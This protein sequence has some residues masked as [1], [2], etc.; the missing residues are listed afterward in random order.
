MWQGTKASSTSS[1][2]KG[3]RR[4]TAHKETPPDQPS[5]LRP[6]SHTNTVFVHARVSSPS[7][8][9]IT[10]TAPQQFPKDHGNHSL[11]SPLPWHQ[12]LG[13]ELPGVP[14]C[15]C[16][17]T[18]TCARKHTPAHGHRGSSRRQPPESNWK[19]STRHV[20]TISQ[21]QGALAWGSLHTQHGTGST[22]QTGE[23]GRTQPA[24]RGKSRLGLPCR[25]GL[26]TPAAPQP[27]APM[28]PP[29]PRPSGNSRCEHLLEA[30]QLPHTRSLDLW[31]L[32]EAEKKQENARKKPMA[33]TPDFHER[34]LQT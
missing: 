24:L 7:G 17:S 10:P 29:T 34:T 27:A 3:S 6:Q 31:H 15:Y 5:C 26:S 4:P 2:G 1:P 23:C 9:E 20:C 28:Q 18:N 25:L 33:T 30:S 32:E 21:S 13:S 14:M 12:P 22:R 16:P 11:Y 19:S 8:S